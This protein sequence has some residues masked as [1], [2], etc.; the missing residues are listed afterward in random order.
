M[1]LNVLISIVKGN[2]NFFVEANETMKIKDVKRIIEGMLNVVPNDQKLMKG[3]M[4][5]NENQTLGELGI[6]K[7]LSGYT[8]P[9]Q[10]QLICRN[11][12]IK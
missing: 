4:E 10:I 6:T 12:G 3:E 7:L 5:M 11:S 8:A 2:V 1:G 9:L